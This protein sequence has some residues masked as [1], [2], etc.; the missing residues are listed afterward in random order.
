MRKLTETDIIRMMNEEWDAKIQQLSESVD[1]NFNAKVDGDETIV[2]DTSMKLKHKKSQLMYT[3][4]SVS[5]REVIL[6]AFDSQK[7]EQP[8]PVDFLVDKDTLE[9]DYEIS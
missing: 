2:L 3:V 6:R 8:K 4:V 1:L 5:P 7:G 9:Q